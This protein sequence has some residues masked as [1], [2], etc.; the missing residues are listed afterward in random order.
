MLKLGPE[1]FRLLN[2]KQVVGNRE[3]V[4]YGEGGL[5]PTEIA[6]IEGQLGFRLPLDFAYLL[7]NV[8]D[9]GAVLFPW[10]NFRKQDYDKA[11]EWIQK[12]VEFDVGNGLWLERWEARPATLHAAI[13]VAKRDFATWPKLLPLFGHRFLA[14]EPYRS[15]NP[16]FSIMQTD[17]VC[18]GA[19]LAHY[20]VNEFVSSDQQRY[21][22]SHATQKIEI[23][24]D[25]ADGS[26]GINWLRP[27]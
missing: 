27:F 14:A 9:P 1:L 26:A 19:N 3:P 11:I 7:E 21:V 10:A 4:I 15:G 24:S 16:I 20:L 23:W 5:S 8:L 12:G 18:Y 17:I 2:E 22:S 13:R 25:F 6:A